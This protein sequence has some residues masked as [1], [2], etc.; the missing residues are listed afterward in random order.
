[1]TDVSDP[2]GTPQQPYSGFGSLSGAL[3]RT[4]FGAPYVMA[5]GAFGGQD[6]VPG[7]IANVATGNLSGP[8]AGTT[9]RDLVL[10]QIIRPIGGPG[11]AE[12]FSRVIGPMDDP[13]RRMAR[14]S[15]EGD[16]PASPLARLLAG[17]R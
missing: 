2:T 6:A 15:I 8:F 13:I 14:D 11:A 5:N 9:A 17:F 12:A 4:L 7:A 10:N 16:Q 3:L 1:M